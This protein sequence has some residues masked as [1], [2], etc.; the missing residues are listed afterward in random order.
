VLC[1]AAVD[2]ADAM[3]RSDA[4][5]SHTNPASRNNGVEASAFSMRSIVSPAAVSYAT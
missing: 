1:C 2:A 5:G 3:S 4:R